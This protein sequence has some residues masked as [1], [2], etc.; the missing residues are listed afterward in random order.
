MATAFVIHH[1]TSIIMIH[2]SWWVTQARSSCGT[3]AEQ[4]RN[5]GTVL[6]QLRNSCGTVAE[7]L[8]GG[9]DVLVAGVAVLVA[10]EIYFLI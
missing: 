10:G 9:I 8:R 2:H 1:S 3:V 5:N 6:E 4:L 7:Q